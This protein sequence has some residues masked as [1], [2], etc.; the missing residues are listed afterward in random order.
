MSTAQVLKATVRTERP[1]TGISPADAVQLA[2]GLSRA[3]AE[4]YVLY[5]KTQGFHW[6]VVGPLFYGLHKLTEAQYADLAA[7]A[8]ELAERIR[9]LGHP[10]PAGFGEF[11][12]L[13]A[14]AESASRMSAEDTV[15][16]LVSDHETVA[17][18]FRGL[19]GTADKAGDVVTADLLTKR[20]HAH[21][22]AAWMLRS[23]VAQ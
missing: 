18:T 4:T 11:L 5:V 8:D 17:R 21:E 22:E 23:I 9:A 15:A 10:A 19:A 3:L 12:K 14:I 7:A 1:R 16:A 6:N 13:S 20:I 2:D